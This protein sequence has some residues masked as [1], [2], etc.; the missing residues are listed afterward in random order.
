MELNTDIESHAMLPN[1]ESLAHD[2]INGH[3]VPFEGIAHEENGPRDVHGTVNWGTFWNPGDLSVAGENQRDV[4]V[5]LSTR[6]P[7]SRHEDDPKGVNDA[8]V[9]AFDYDFMRRL[10][11]RDIEA[12]AELVKIAESNPNRAVRYE[13]SLCGMS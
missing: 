8:R 6:A 13:V 1:G 3:A 9:V 10:L 7:G 2:S 4:W 5:L 12:E 11:D